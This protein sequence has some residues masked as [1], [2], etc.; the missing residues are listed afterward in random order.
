MTYTETSPPIGFL[1]IPQHVFVYGH[2]IVLIA[3][4]SVENLL[5]ILIDITFLRGFPLIVLGTDHARM[6]SQRWRGRF[7]SFSSWYKMANNIF[8]L[9]IFL[10]TPTCLH[11]KKDTNAPMVNYCIQKYTSY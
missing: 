11:A 6:F 10:L 4:E 3:Q 8:L 2:R 1:N 5:K 7:F 9:T